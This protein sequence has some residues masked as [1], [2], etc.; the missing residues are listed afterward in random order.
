MGG[1]T[2][3]Y[4]ATTTWVGRTPDEPWDYPTYSRSY[5]VSVIGKPDLSGS[6]TPVFHGNHEK[7]NPEDLFLAAVSACHM[8]SYLAL[9]ARRG[10]EVLHYVDEARGVLELHREG[11]GQFTEIELRPCVTLAGEADAALAE[12]LHTRAHELC[13]IANSCRCPIQLA[14]EVHATTNGS[15]DRT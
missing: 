13:F 14:A 12:A 10:V 9:C 2:H 1:R 7:H 4:R 6:A 5:T 3:D 15:G 8:L 11:G